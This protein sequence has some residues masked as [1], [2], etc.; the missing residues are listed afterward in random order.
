MRFLTAAGLGALLVLAAPGLSSAAR[1][2]EALQS[3]YQVAQTCTPSECV[4]VCVC[5]LRFGAVR[6]CALEAREMRARRTHLTGRL[7]SRAVFR[8][9]ASAGSAR[10][11]LRARA[12]GERARGRHCRAPV[13][14]Y[15]LT[16]ASAHA[17]DARPPTPA[18]NFAAHPPPRETP[19][20]LPPIPPPRAPKP[21]QKHDKTKTAKA[22]IRQ[23]DASRCSGVPL[24]TDCMM[25]L[26]VTVAPDCSAS[27]QPTLPVASDGTYCEPSVVAQRGAAVMGRYNH[28]TNL[29]V[30]IAPVMGGGGGAGAFAVGVEGSFPR[31]NGGG[32]EMSVRCVMAY[33][34]AEGSLLGAT[35]PAGGAGGGGG[36]SMIPLPGQAAVAVVEQREKDAAKAAA[37]AA[38][39]QKE[40]LAAQRAA[41]GSLASAGGA[42]VRLLGG[43]GTLAGKFLRAGVAAAALLAG[44]VVSA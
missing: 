22:I 7:I 26:A 43:S 9:E 23:K 25:G 21:N 16:T 13:L 11:R 17:A 1:L 20:H 31:G 40:A 33:A 5:V 10:K 44:A 8:T 15:R 14:G 38:L 3:P 30:S 4:C 18:H 34:L 32:Q 28:G 37:A 27:L 12:R 24:V 36:S 19:P 39:A 35:A 29:A 42:P 6:S 2:D 41:P